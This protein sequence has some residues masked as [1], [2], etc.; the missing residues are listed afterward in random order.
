M[1]GAE[2]VVAT[3]ERLGV[4]RVFAIPGIQNLELFDALADAPFPTV[5]VAHEGSAAFM[6]DAVGRLTGRPG[7]LAIV[8]GPGVTYAA[9]GLAVALANARRLPLAQVMR[10]GARV[11]RRAVLDR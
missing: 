5:Q 11:L 7:V 4:E 6:A 10:I 8:P 3:L 9:T 2:A 1:T